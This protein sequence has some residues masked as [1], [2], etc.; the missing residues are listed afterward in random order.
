M[1]RVA[2]RV[3]HSQQFRPGGAD[4]RRTI[5]AINLRIRVFTLLSLLVLCAFAIPIQAAVWAPPTVNQGWWTPGTHIGV[6]GGFEQ[7]TAGGASD[8]AVTGTLVDITAAPYNADPTGVIPADT[9]ITNAIALASGP[10]VIYFP[11]GTYKIT[12]GYFYSGYKDNITIRGAGA[13]STTFHCSMAANNVAFILNS[14]GELTSN[15]RTVTGTKTKGT[16]TLS[17]ADTTGYVVGAHVKVSYENETNNV[18]IQAGAVPVWS[19]IGSTNIRAMVAQITAVVANTSITITPPLPADGTDLGVIT[20]IYPLNNK[21]TNWG[22]EDFSVSFDSANHPRAFIYI[23]SAENC[24]V[25]RVKFLNWSKTTSGGSC[26]NLFNT[27]WCEVRKCRFNAETGSSSDGAIGT[28]L[29]TSALIIDNIFTG[30]WDVLTYDNGNSQNSVVAYNFAIGG[31]GSYFHNAHPSLNL[32]EGNVFPSHQSDGFHGSS[33]HNTLFRNWFKTY[34]V[35]NRFK[36]NYV[37]AGNIIGVD[38][39]TLGQISWGN[40]NI[41]NGAAN[42]F[43]GPTGL[44]DQVGQTD[45]SQPGYGF[46]EY[47]IQPADVSAGDFWADWRATGTLS[48]RTSDTIGVFTVSGG[49]WFVGDSPTAANSLLVHARTPTVLMYSG[50]VTAVAGSSVTVSFAGGTL[51]AQSTV[52]HLYP[53]PAGFQERDLDVQASSTLAANYFASAGGTGSLTDS[54]APDTFPDSLMYAAKPDWFYG[55]DWPAFTSS[56]YATADSTRI[57]AG[58]RYANSDADPPSGGASGAF[59]AMTNGPG[60]M[61]GGNR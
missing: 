27:L 23:D 13:G 37:I 8:R 45:Y 57:P 61:R 3:L 16:S 54:I 55:L 12:N 30:P 26:V 36:R 11:A 47:V 52:M 43:A 21:T 60:L 20:G 22:F 58:Y 51:P 33:S 50:T 53:G 5:A 28:G 15:Q 7:Y 10:T 35:L 44:S 39:S 25:Y 48:T 31:Q 34:V 2:G 4:T 38:G 18:R 24:W 6:A 41:G 56:S 14:P 9:A 19:G 42:G 32:F 1:R 40:P 17:I 59:A 49:N 46:N 29:S